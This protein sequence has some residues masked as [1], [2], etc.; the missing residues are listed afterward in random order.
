MR[1]DPNSIGVSAVGTA[2]TTV[3]STA[4]RVAIPADSEGKPPKYIRVAVIN[5]GVVYVRPGASVAV[6]STT[7]DVPVAL[8]TPL[9]LRVG[10]NT[11]LG[12]IDNGTVTNFV[13]T[14]LDDQ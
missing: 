10:G 8:A 1:T 14:P 13:I 11:H 6:T 2:V 4:N 12:Y 3:A 9:I 5:T 7:G